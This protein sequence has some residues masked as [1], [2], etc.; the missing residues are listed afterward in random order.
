MRRRA[1]APWL[2]AFLNVP[3]AVVT[4][5]ASLAFLAWFCWERVSGFKTE[6]GLQDELAGGAEALSA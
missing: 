5:V 4:N 6:L 2:F 3:Y 1:P